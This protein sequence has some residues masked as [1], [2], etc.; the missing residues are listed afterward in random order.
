MINYLSVDNG[1]WFKDVWNIHDEVFKSNGHKIPEQTIKS[2]RFEKFENSKIENE[3]KYYLAYSLKTQRLSAIT[4]F[5]NYRFP[6]EF[7]REYMNRA[8]VPDNLSGMQVDMGQIEMILRNRGITTGGAKGD[9]YRYYN[10]LYGDLWTLSRMHT[11]NA[12]C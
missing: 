8:G 12:P 5:K 2:I 4:V 1:Y 3:I 11:M 6:L 10:I 7:M 9:C